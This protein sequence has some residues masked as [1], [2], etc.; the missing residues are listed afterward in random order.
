[1]RTTR[2]VATACGCL[3]LQSL[4]CAADAI[5]FDTHGGDAWTFT[6]TV[7][8]QILANACDEVIVAAPQAQVR[9][10]LE[11]ERFTARIPLQ[12]GANSVTA[13]CLRS[14]RERVRTPPQ[15]WH[16]RLPDSP[17]ARIRARID[18]HRLLLDARGSELAPGSPVKLANVQWRLLESGARS[19]QAIGDT[20]V[21]EIPV[22]QNDGEYRV[23]LEVADAR[24]RRDKAAA[25]L[26]VRNG[27]P[28]I[29]DAVHEAP[30]WVDAAVLY[31]VV[32][33]FFEGY[34]GVRERLDE[35]AA[36]GATAIWISPVTAAANGD[37]G[38]A[39]VD[40][41]RLRDTFGDE[42]EFR[43]LVS[44]AHAAGLRVILDFVPNHFSDHHRYSLDAERD[45]ERSPYFKWFDRDAQGAVTHY[46][47][48]PHL[49]NL[50]LDHP[51]VRNYLIAAFAHWLIEYDVDGFRVDAAWAITQRAPEF[52]DR[53]R[54]ALKRIEP[55]VL[56]LAEAA[57][58]DAQAF[59][60][61]YDWTTQIGEW[62][63]RDI[64][65]D[66]QTIPDLARLREALAIPADVPRLRFVG[67]NDTGAR[68]I[69]R[70]GEA[71]LRL[72]AA[73]TFTIPGI[74]LIYNGDEIGAEF[75]PYDEG[76]PLQWR[77]PRKLSAYYRQLS[78][79]RERYAALRSHE[80]HV[81]DTS[82]DERVLAFLRP[83]KRCQD[84]VLVVFNFSARPTQPH[85]HAP[86]RA[87]ALRDVA[88]N[89]RFTIRKHR[90][91][92]DLAPYS[93]RV[94]RTDRCPGL[95]IDEGNRPAAA[96]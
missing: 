86:I 60:A 36:L 12:A 11:A 23:Q 82:E 78:Q 74:P 72:G 94:L 8:G 52:W 28:R 67:N 22:P 83:M 6:K 21:A 35:I 46:F 14:G 85:I 26:E 89:A 53:W 40:H 80:L 51:E 57:P 81:L 20:P 4:A 93:W 77:D 15:V 73:L 90:A 38:Y 27:Q 19:S 25:L 65:H 70:H 18:A 88:T 32:P 39:T 66:A 42:R 96:R 54:R 17:T 34:A 56:L 47:D 76:P 58:Q 55:N 10:V 44:A 31:G 29:I 33:F 9:A 45:G 50:N 30:A 3:V 7:E 91:R 16:V 48:W 64:F 59:D 61:A 37:F 41:F 1:M 63:W 68:F 43:A 95:T 49:N 75:E 13:V 84:E 71:Y 62:S 5:R 92:V 69:T 2:A 24:G 87:Q 79:L